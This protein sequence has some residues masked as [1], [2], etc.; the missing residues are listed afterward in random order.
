MAI[1]WTVAAWWCDF[2]PLAIASVALHSNHHDPLSHCHKT[3]SLACTTFLRFCAWAWF[4][5][6]TYAACTHAVVFDCLHSSQKYFFSPVYSIFKFYIEFYSQI[7]SLITFLLWGLLLPVKRPTKQ[8][9]KNILNIHLLRS[10]STSSTSKAI[11]SIKI[12]E[13]IL[14]WESCLILISSPSLIIISLFGIV[15]QYLICTTIKI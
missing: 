5:P 15:W 7:L 6:F 11:R 4:W 12:L 2:Y 13:N 1:P 9:L 8:V 3:C 14:F 10:S